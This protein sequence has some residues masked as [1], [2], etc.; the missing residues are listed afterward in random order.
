MTPFAAGLIGAAL[1]VVAAGAQQAPA[2]TAADYARAEQ[3]LITNTLPLVSGVSVQPTWLSGDRVGYRN[4]VRGIV[5]IVLVDPSKRTRVV[6]SPDSDRCGG[7]LDPREVTRLRSVSQRP[8]GARPESLSPDGR[9]AAFIRSYN[10]WVRD[11]ATGRETQL[12][13]DGQKDFGYATD[14]AGW[15]RSDR[16]VLVWSPDSRKIATFQQD[17]RGVGEMY[18]VN[19]S[20]GH[21]EL[22]AWKYPLPG[23][24]L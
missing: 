22:Q 23:D 10:L 24:S 16:P 8:A 3:F 6:C 20:V 21:P 1:I 12:T 11:V 5:Q 17:E 9:R 15:V 19:T 13:T 14:N 4:V 7:A 2:V 18:L